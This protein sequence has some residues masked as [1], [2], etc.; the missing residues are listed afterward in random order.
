VIRLNGLV[1]QFIT[2]DMNGRRRKKNSDGHGDGDDGLFDTN[3]D[4]KFRLD[5]TFLEELDDDEQLDIGD[6]LI[7]SLNQKWQLGYAKSGLMRKE[8]LEH[9]LAQGRHRHRLLRQAGRPL[10]SV[11][12]HR[13][14]LSQATSTATWRMNTII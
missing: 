13:C 2:H 3:G 12:E 6:E 4:D 9:P 10:L 8:A 1:L 5:D 14:R 7:S 11:L